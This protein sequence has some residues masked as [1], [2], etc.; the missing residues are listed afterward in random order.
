MKFTPDGGRVTIAARR[1]GEVDEI[2]VSDTGI[3]IDPAFLPNVF[4]SFRQADASPTRVHGG[5]GLGLS[6]VRQ[7]VALHGGE[8]SAESAGKDK[9]ATFT[10]R[11]PVR[12]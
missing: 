10:V 2:V 3:G 1:A 12:G 6:I 7:L 11:L 4:E 9:G 5:L 8:V